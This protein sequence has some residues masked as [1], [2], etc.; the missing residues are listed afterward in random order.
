MV[1]ELLVPREQLRLDCDSENELCE[2]M[3]RL[4]HQ[5]KVS[6]LVIV[7]RLFDLGV[8]DQK[9]LRATYRSEIDRVKALS[10]RKSSSGDIFNTLSTRTGKRF[11]KA[12]VASTREEQPQFTDAFKMLGIK[13]NTTF[14]KET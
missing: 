5:F 13:K 12:L 6:T 1:T 4:A 11:V 8:F 2:E 9:M 14:Y 7:H 10:A 3:Q